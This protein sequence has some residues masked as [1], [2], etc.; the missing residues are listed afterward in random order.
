MLARGAL[1]ISL[2]AGMPVWRMPTVLPVTGRATYYAEGVMERVWQYRIQSGDV[3]PCK[4]CIGAVAMMHSG[5]I[6]RKVWVEHD[7]EVLGPFIVVDCAAPQDFPALER[8]GIVVEVPYWLARHWKM[9]GP[10]GVR[11]LDRPAWPVQE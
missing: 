3:R 5:D 7:G 8:R 10:V 1:A 6:G 11:V 4:E 2:L 9:A